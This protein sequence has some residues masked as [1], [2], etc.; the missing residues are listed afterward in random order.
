MIVLLLLPIAGCHK[1]EPSVVDAPADAPEGYYPELK[2][3]AQIAG[4]NLAINVLKTR[5]FLKDCGILSYF[6]GIP[7]SRVLVHN[8]DVDAAAEF[9]RK[10]RGLVGVIVHERA[11]QVPRPKSGY[12][13]DLMLLAWIGGKRHVELSMQLTRI[14]KE[15]GIR[16]YCESLSAG[17]EAMVHDID[18]DRAIRVL[19]AHLD[20]LGP[21]VHLRNPPEYL[22]EER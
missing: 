9:L 5:Q 19:T 13:P 15:N 7:V 18:A 3:I 1:P 16:A 2:E 21:D 12:P 6:Q 22:Q 10:N 20:A 8:R 11:V 4:E 17:S 14:M